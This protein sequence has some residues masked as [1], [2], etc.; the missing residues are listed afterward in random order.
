MKYDPQEGNL[1]EADADISICDFKLKKSDNDILADSN[2][3]NKPVTEKSS[4]N[5]SA[6][7]C[8]YI[9]LMV[10][11]LNHTFLVFQPLKELYSTCQFSP[12]SRTF[13]H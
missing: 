4:L 12:H 7:D 8:F 13:I 10:N 2:Y 9:L 11:G 3:K 1:C 5:T 6:C